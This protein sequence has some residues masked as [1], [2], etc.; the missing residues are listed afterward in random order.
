MD[1]RRVRRDGHVDRPRTTASSTV[2]GDRHRP[3]EGPRG[4]T[5]RTGGDRGVGNVGGGAEALAGREALA[6]RQVRAASNTSTRPSLGCP[7]GA[8]SKDPRN[9][10]F[11]TTR[12]GP[13]HQ[14]PRHHGERATTWAHAVTGS[15]PATESNGEEIDRQLVDRRPARSGRPH[16]RSWPDRP[17]SR[18]PEEGGIP[19]EGVEVRREGRHR[20]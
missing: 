19:S 8:T 2:D 13:R 6:Q 17:R 15:A 9:S 14:L 10:A 7:R 12:T 5:N 3:A 1:D 20:R 11:I 16:R 18:R 4:L